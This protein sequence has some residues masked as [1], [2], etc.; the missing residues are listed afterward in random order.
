MD[1]VQMRPPQG[2]VPQRDRSCQ[3]RVI[4]RKKNA[5]EKERVLSG[6]PVARDAL[7]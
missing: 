5:R 7:T 3:P 6:G 4:I 1:S 2:A